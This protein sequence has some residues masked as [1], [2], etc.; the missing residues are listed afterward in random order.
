MQYPNRRILGEA[1]LD[2]AAKAADECPSDHP[3]DIAIAM[4]AAIEAGAPAIYSFW[5][6]SREERES[7]GYKQA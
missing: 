3:T 7:N 2:A 5:K 6:R 4:S 1:L